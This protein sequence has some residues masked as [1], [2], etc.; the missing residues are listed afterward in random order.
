[1][2]NKQILSQMPKKNKEKKLWKNEMN[3]KIVDNIEETQNPS[4]IAEKV[5]SGK[6]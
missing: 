6:T 2:N 5:C 4:I 1:M 3:L